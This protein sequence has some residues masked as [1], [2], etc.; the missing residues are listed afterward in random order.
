MFLSN[1]Q[2]PG[3]PLLIPGPILYALEIKLIQHPVYLR[4]TERPSCGSHWEGYQ[5][6][7][8][9]LMM[10]LA[11]TTMGQA[12]RFPRQISTW[13]DPGNNSPYMATGT[14][15]VGSLGSQAGSVNTWTCIQCPQMSVWPWIFMVPRGVMVTLHMVQTGPWMSYR[16]NPL[17]IVGS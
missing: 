4:A 15:E 9:D 16:Q 13:E 7:L 11:R 1:Q 10:I 14:M 6:H 2:L 17:C 3:L 8:I 5:L 12:P